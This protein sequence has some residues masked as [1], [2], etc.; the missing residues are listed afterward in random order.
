MI[1]DHVIAAKSQA[2]RMFRTAGVVDAGHAASHVDDE[3]GRRERRPSRSQEHLRAPPQHVHVEA[4]YTP[5][6]RQWSMSSQS[7]MRLYFR[8]AGLFPEES[9]TLPL[10]HP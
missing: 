2:W 3:V 5:T 6:D 10:D 1:V 7:Q 9:T 8:Q 4:W